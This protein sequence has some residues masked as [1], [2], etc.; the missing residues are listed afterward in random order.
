RND[1]EP[2][3]GAGVPEG[4]SQEPVDEFFENHLARKRLRGF[5]HCREIEMLD[6]RFDRTHRTPPGLF[7]LQ[8]RMEFIELPY[9][10][11]GA[12]SQIAAPRVFQVE[13]RDVLEAARSVKA[14]SQLAGERFNM[15]EVVRSRRA[16]RFFVEAL[17]VEFPIFDSGYL[18]AN[19]GGAA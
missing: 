11:V 19:D 9:L 6:R 8:L 13:T 5:N 14:S 12:P 10:S 3:L 1:Q 4:R 18:G 17:C 16:D 2:S 7:L 15:H